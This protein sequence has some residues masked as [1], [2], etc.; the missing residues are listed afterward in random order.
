MREKFIAAF[1][2]WQHDNATRGDIDGCVES[3]G[4]LQNG[5]NGMLSQEAIEA[6]RKMMGIQQ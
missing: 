6:L 1:I 4:L 5:E 2:R 3:M